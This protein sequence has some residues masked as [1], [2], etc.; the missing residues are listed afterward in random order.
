MIKV[1]RLMFCV[2]GLLVCSLLF[3]KAEPT[4]PKVEA[5]SAGS[6]PTPKPLTEDQQLGRQILESS[7]AMARGLEPPMRSY[8]LLQIA[9]A[10][11]ST[12]KAKAARLLRDAFTAAVA[13]PDDK[14]VKDTK[15]RL[16]QPILQALLPLSQSDVEER[17]LQ[18]DPGVR[19]GM[20]DAIVHLYADK[21]QFAPALELVN[22]MTAEDEFPY[23]SG[24]SLIQAMPAEMDGEKQSLFAQAITSYSQHKHQSVNVHGGGLVGMVTRF[25]ASMPPKL[26][27]EAIDEILKQSKESN[28]D[29]ASITMSSEQGTLGFSSFYEYE[30]FAFLPLLRQLDESRAKSLLEENQDLAAKLKQ[31]PEGVGSLDPELAVR[32]HELQRQAEDTIDS[33]GKDPVQAIAQAAT[34]PA[35]LADNVFQSP[36]GHVLETIAKINVKNH[37]A[38]ARQAVD[39]LKKMAEDLAPQAQVIYLASAADL[40]LQLG[41]QDSAERIVSKGF[42]AA[43]ALL[44]KDTDADDPNLA[45][46]AWWPSADAYRRFIEVEAKISHSTTANILKEIKDPEIRTVESIIVARTLLGDPP[47][48]YQIT[49]RKRVGD[50]YST[51]SSSCGP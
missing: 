1:S 7:E 3:E 39:E 12:D 29:E 32:R 21:K 36:R 47:K 45:L 15:S 16:E 18:A 19:K 50:G 13:I 22:R 35:S 49:R 14:D 2:A 17:L 30:L 38:V 48:G 31:F 9:Q 33:A 24:A 20:S 26:A 4:A 42:K 34:L 23:G 6:K 41:D 10:Y 43:E 11:V 25:S 8:S 28:S 37:P 27:L 44:E 46:K 51:T 40:Y 5:P